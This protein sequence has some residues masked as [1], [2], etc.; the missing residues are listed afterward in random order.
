MQL[1]VAIAFTRSTSGSRWPGC[2]CAKEIC[3]KPVPKLDVPE[4]ES[5]GMGYHWGQVDANRMLA[6]LGNSDVGSEA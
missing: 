4:S 2:I 6:L 1:R 5:I 3:L